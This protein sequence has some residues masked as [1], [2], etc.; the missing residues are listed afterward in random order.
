LVGDLDPVKAE[1]E[2]LA[3]VMPHF[4]LVVVPEAN[5]QDA[6]RKPEFLGRLKD[7]LSDGT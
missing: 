6:V 3:R 2:N 5:H 4:H 7:F 1:A